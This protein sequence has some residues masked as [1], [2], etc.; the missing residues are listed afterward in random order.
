MIATAHAHVSIICL[1]PL[2]VLHQS[3]VNQRPTTITNQC[4]VDHYRDYASMRETGS[5]GWE[6]MGRR[7]YPQ[8]GTFSWLSPALALTQGI[9]Q[10]EL[11]IEH[12]TA[13]D[14][15]VLLENEG[16]C[17]FSR[18]IAMCRHP[19]HPP[20]SKTSAL[21]HFWGRL[22]S[23][24]TTLENEHVRSFSRM[25]TLCCH[26]R[27]PPL[28][29]TSALVIFCQHQQ[30]QHHPLSPPSLEKEQRARF[31]GWSLFATTTMVHPP[32][33]LKSSAYARFRGCLLCATA[34]SL[35]P[36]KR[37]STHVFDAIFYF[38]MYIIILITNK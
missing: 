2:V 19:H 8:N 27:H 22:L 24:T 37:V 33:P 38:L 18:V 29:N 13:C 1:P 10:Q 23:A 17:S 15:W 11:H 32:P 21:A 7:A 5:Q 35:L 36:R 16:T 26:R 31:R 28:S 20:L 25:V 12:K 3:H 30:Q 14:G 34:T 9:L 4:I 6:G